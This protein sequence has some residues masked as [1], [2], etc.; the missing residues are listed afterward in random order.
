MAKKEIK[1]IV[2]FPFGAENYRLMLIGIG[3]IVLGTVLMAG[4]G[5]DSPGVWNPAIFSFQRITLSPILI[6]LGLVIEVYAILKK[7]AS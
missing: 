2:D 6:V 7:S 4:G 3:V 1:P 5:S